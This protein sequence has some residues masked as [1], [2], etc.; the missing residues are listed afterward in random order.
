ME[1]RL[2]LLVVVVLLLPG[3]AS[4]EIIVPYAGMGNNLV[5]GT[6]SYYFG[7]RS[8]P[9]VLPH[10]C[11]ADL[12]SGAADVYRALRLYYR[13][14]GR[15]FGERRQRLVRRLGDPGRIWCWR[16]ACCRGGTAP[17]GVVSRGRS[18]G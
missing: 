3:L 4:A 14:A 1:K 13:L 16:R 8:R 5:N 10:H 11:V 9:G 15:H 2:F 6:P 12:G 7:D 17:H 18:G